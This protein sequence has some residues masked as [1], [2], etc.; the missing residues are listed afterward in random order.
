MI[1]LWALV[2]S[3]DTEPQMKWL[4]FCRQHFQKHFQDI[5]IMIEICSWGYN[6]QFFRMGS[7][8]WC[9]SGNKPLPDLMITNFMNIYMS[10]VLNQLITDDTTIQP[11]CCH[12]TYENFCKH[13][14]YV[15]RLKRSQCEIYKCEMTMKPSI[16]RLTF[17]WHCGTL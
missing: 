16:I 17:H 4:A 3:L 1:Y 12:E 11:L 8:A 2:A 14:F 10:P 13:I 5:C 9:Q 15:Y 6:W 7:M